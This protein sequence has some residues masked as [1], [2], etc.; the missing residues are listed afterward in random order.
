MRNWSPN[1]LGGLTLLSF[2]LGAYACSASGGSD[3]PSGAS[4]SSAGGSGGTSSGGIGNV[5]NVGGS[6]NTGGFGNIGNIGGSSG[7]STVGPDGCA[8]VSQK[9]EVITSYSAIALFIMQDFTGTM[10][11]GVP[12]GSPNSWPNS[13]NALTGFVNDPASQGL[14]VGL[15]FFPPTSGLPD[16][17]CGGCVP[18]VPIGPITQTGPQIVNAMNSNTPNPLNFTPLQCGLQGMISACQAFMQQTGERCVAVFV[19]DGNTADPAP[20][21][22]DTNTANLLNIVSQGNAAGVTTYALGVVSGAMAFV[23]QVAQAGGTNT[24]FDVTQGSQAFLA[25]LNSIRSSVAVQTTLDCQWIIPDSTTG[26]TID[27]SKVNLNFTPGGGTAQQIAQ[28]PS[29]SDCA[30]A[31]NGWY[32]DDP[33]NPTQVLVCPQTCDMLKASTDGQVDLLFGCDTVVWVK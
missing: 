26:Q 2:A 28:V 16:A 15:G 6:N 29:Q 11:T 32:Y 24:G 8:A 13:V 27:P 10:V 18:V 9:P 3:R 21:G 30:A 17:Q 25:A 7:S 5:G 20:P 4:G 14:D 23:N 1:H 31:G 19:T 33:T 12:S 22:C